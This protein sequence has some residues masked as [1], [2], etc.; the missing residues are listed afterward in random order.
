MEQFALAVIGSGSG[1]VVIPHDRSGGKVA[2]I[3]AGAFGGTCLNRG[4][5]PTKMLVYTAD[6]AMQ[7]RRASEF[8]LAATLEEV[9]WTAIRDRVMTRVHKILAC[10]P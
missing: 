9:D 6:V 1:N 7:V 8:G 4:C 3:E 2:L 5:I 10:R